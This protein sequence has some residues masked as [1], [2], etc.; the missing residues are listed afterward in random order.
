LLPVSF[1]VL[2]DVGL[3]IDGETVP[4]GHARQQCVLVALLIDAN[5]PVFVDDLIERVWG[6]HPPQ[7]ARASLYSYLSRLRHALN[8]ADGVDIVRRS[9]GYLLL[10]DDSLVDMHRFRQLVAQAQH[11]DDERA[12]ELLRQALDLWRGTPFAGLDTPWLNTVRRRLDGERVAAELAWN[13][14]QLRRG[15]HLELLPGLRE[16]F[17]A[18]PLDE[19]IAA[20][21]M[22][23]LYRSG[24]T[25]DALDVFLRLRRQLAEHLG[26]DPSLALTQLHQRILSADASLSP[27]GSTSAPPVPRQLPAPPALFTGRVTELA[28]LDKLTAVPAS[29]R[30]LSVAVI[31]GVGGLGKSQLALHWAYDHLDQFPDGQLYVDLRGFEP[32]AEPV[33]VTVALRGLL[34][35][36]GVPAT[37]IPSELPAQTALYR[38]QIAGRRMLVLLDN[39]RD[40]D[41]VVPLLPGSPSC[42]VLVTSR[43]QLTGLLIA[44]G[45]QLVTPT[46]LD[47]TESYQLLTD[48][49]GAERVAAES[50]AVRELVA[51]C[52]GL[53]LALAIL[54]AR[55]AANPSFPLSTLAEELLDTTGQLDA[56]DGGEMA[57]SLSAVFRTSCQALEPDAAHLFTLLGVAHGPDLSAPAA[58]ALAG[59]PLTVT[60]N[61][62]RQLET[63]HLVEQYVPGRYRM[64]NL[65]R[66]YAE[67]RVEH[68]PAAAVR[69]LIDFYL[70]GAVAADRA[71]APHRAPVE[72]DEPAPGSAPQEIPDQPAAMA[73]FQSEHECVMAAQL[74]AVE[75]GLVDRAW[76]LAWALSTFHSWQGRID[77]DLTMWRIGH[78]AAE[79]LGDP[80]VRAL[81]D[82]FLGRALDRAGQHVEAMTHLRRAITLLTQVGDPFGAAHTHRAV[83]SSL[84]QQGNLDEALAHAEEALALYETIGR[85]A[86][87][88]EALELVG[89]YQARLGD[90]ERARANCERA[91]D[92]HRQHG[93]REGEANTRFSLGHIAHR[94]HD[95][96]DALRHFAAALALY[97]ELGDLAHEATTLSALG[98]VTADTGRVDEARSLW[99][100][101]L[102]LYVVQGRTT[103]IERVRAKLAE[104]S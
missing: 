20:Q 98:D 47:D 65:V 74:S 82:R 55:A 26:A 45:A 88:A 33:P 14:I 19:R 72:L 4:V 60:R 9:G 8:A 75:Y 73:W 93:N 37:A 49:L 50:G 32:A 29:G 67:R 91:L 17:A 51:H 12:A 87:A 38:S 48:A 97:G 90:Y 42:V 35:A 21:L 40:T 59:L 18:D 22:L 101:A 95:L 36:L 84:E 15:R 46:V 30:R 24:R 86:W 76:Q 61:L 43:R 7:R 13:E 83:A 6:H 104:P 11:S 62:L 85:P 28:V 64:H 63:M 79:R 69:R 99:R 54:A 96:R 52:G 23:A 78:A 80:A 31:S 2:G 27:S 100:R 70:F 10:V 34:N 41:Q 5:R 57:A 66:L 92:L 53:P 89:W 77:A 39:A 102:D 103:E 68:E 71:L 94:T 56:L 58:S 3:V 1:R 25:S 81:A 16:R 44:H